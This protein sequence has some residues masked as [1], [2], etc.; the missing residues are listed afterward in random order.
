MNSN[1]VAEIQ[2]TSIPDEQL[3]PSTCIR[4]HICI[5][6]QVAPPG[7][8]FHASGRHVCLLY[9]GVNAALEI[10]CKHLMS[11]AIISLHRVAIS[12]RPS[13][14]TSPGVASS[15]E[16]ICSS[17]R[18]LLLHFCH[19]YLNPFNFAIYWLAK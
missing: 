12:T 5:R 18:F 8:I 10:P 17:A 19:L 11:L 15:A 2:S 6:I 4:R 16:G 7:H 9:H 1:Y 13:G 14:R 3:Y